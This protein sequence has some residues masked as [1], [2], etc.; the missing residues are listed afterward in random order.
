MARTT[1][2]HLFSSANGVN[3][4]PHLFQFDAFGAEEGAAMD[5]TLSG[6]TDVVMGRTL[7]EEWSQHFPQADDGFA[8]F[9][10]PVRKHVITSTMEGELGW[11]SHAIDGD[12]IDFVN[13]LRNRDGGDIVIAGGIETVRTLFLAGMVDTL[14]LTMHPAV[15]GDG[16][17]LFDESVPLTRLRLVEATSTPQDNVIVTYA[18]RD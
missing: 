9:I 15:T 5:A 2:A 6:A 14:T 4:S 18:L 17:R 12:P 7:W 11:N 10:N 3:E 16:R 13:D 1:S 8:T